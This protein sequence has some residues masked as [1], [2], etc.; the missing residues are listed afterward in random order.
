MIED[1]Q[2]LVELARSG[3]L[4]AFRTL[5]ERYKKRV[6]GLALDLTG[7]H[8]DAEDLSQEVFIKAYRSLGAFRGDAKLGSWLY[9]I[10]VNMAINKRR[11]RAFAA[12]IFRD[13]LD[14]P[15]AGQ[16]LSASGDA[17]GD[18]ERSAESGLIQ[19]H[20]ERALR[21][22]PPRQRA[23]FVLRHYHDLPLKEVASVLSVSEGTVK[24]LLFRAIRRLRKELSF[25]R[26]DL[27][28]EESK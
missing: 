26:Q 22:L 24:S 15:T 28:L 8:H 13:D 1:E 5:V 20:V 10:T 9:R 17:G 2:R 19:L 12:L 23:V 16:D 6:Y 14:R 11:R 3:Q 21:R 4:A 27:G 25:Y 7:N 18:P